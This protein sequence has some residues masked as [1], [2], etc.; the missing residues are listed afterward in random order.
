VFVALL[1]SLEPT[2]GISRT[3]ICRTR[4][5]CSRERQRCPIARG[6]LDEHV[7]FECLVPTD[8]QILAL[9]RRL[10]RLLALCLDLPPAWFLDRFL[11][12]IAILRPLHYSPR[13][14]QPEEVC[15]D[16]SP[17]VEHGCPL[18]ISPHT[19]CMLDGD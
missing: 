4:G 17:F 13:L 1:T 8:V 19:R 15:S 12:P 3:S 5:S 2:V 11:K 7:R 10:L 9:G 18:A 6:P 16:Q 14:S